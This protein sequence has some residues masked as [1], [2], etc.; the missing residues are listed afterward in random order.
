MS[1]I[2]LPDPFAQTR[3]YLARVLPWPQNGEPPMY[4]NICN[5]FMPS[6]G[7]V[8]TD[9]K[10]K[11]IYPW[12]GR[13]ARSLDEAISYLDFSLNKHSGTRD[14]YVC[15]STQREPGKQKDWRQG[16]HLLRGQP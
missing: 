8:K 14:V 11:K 13:A 7:V 6:N 16:V 3:Q 1:I 2:P 12:G 10:G 9:A 5:T 4:V 15:M